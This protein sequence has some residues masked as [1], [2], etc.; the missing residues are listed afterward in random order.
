[1]D[2]ILSL[3]EIEAQFL[4]GWV[5]IKNP[6]NSDTLEIQSGKV[7]FHS[8]DRDEVYHQAV[9]RQP[10]RFAVLYTGKISNDAAIVL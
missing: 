4:S 8:K 7:L 6:Q 2:K 1:M 10:K 9:V 5:L 3:S